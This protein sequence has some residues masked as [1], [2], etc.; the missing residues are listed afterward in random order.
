MNV[1]FRHYKVNLAPVSLDSKGKLLL[2][3][4]DAEFAQFGAYDLIH[5][6]DLGYYAS[7]HRERK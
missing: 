3:Y 4:T 7:A 2:G 1:F 6:D 5:P